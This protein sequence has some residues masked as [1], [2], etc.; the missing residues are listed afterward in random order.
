MTVKT[1]V[2]MPCYNALK[3]LGKSVGSVLEQTSEDW[4]LIVVD[5][6]STD[7]SW[8]A[9]LNLAETDQRIRVFHQRNSGAAIARNRALKEARGRYI[10]F[11]DAD[12][13]WHPDFLVSMETVL[14]HDESVGIA[15]CGWQNIGLGQGRDDLFIPPD[16]ERNDKIEILLQGCRWPIH[17]ALVRSQLVHS[18]G[19]FDEKLSSCMDY[20][21][22]LRLG[23]TQRLARVSEVLAYYHHHD[24]IQITKNSARIALNHWVVQRKYLRDNPS[25]K[26]KL[27]KVK[28][29]NLTDGELLKRGYECYWRR[30]LP[31]ARAIF[32]GVMRH[33]YGGIRDWV[34][35]LPALLP[36]SMHRFL[37]HHLE[38]PSARNT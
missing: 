20:D 33:G 6:G 37:I 36:V 38:T 4:E 8:Q 22:W 27:G 5:D 28:T 17:A 26:M 30:D 35:M 3:H 24:G 12:D 13:T 11:L 2:I 16:Y 25:I 31:A 9:L 32:R 19:G 14:D 15:Y 1:S 21:L 10:A 23:S 34:Y 29:R 18:C 7:T